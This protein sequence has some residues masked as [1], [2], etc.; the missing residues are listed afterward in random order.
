LAGSY[1]AT[2]VSYDLDASGNR[3]AAGGTA[4]GREYVFNFTQYRPTSVRYVLDIL[5][6]TIPT[7]NF[8]IVKLQDPSPPVRGTFR[9]QFEN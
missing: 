6:S 2:A 5:G 7:S 9:L 1:Y 4:A 8:A 3:I